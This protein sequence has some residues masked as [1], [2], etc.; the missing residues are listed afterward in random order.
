AVGPEIQDVVQGDGGR[1]GA[2]AAPLGCPFLLRV[3]LPLCQ[4]TR[5]QPLL[6]VAHDALVP[7][8]VRD[9]LPQPG[10][11]NRLKRPNIFIPLSTTHRPTT[12]QKSRPPPPATRFS[13]PFL[14]CSRLARALT[15]WAISLSPTATPWSCGPPSP[16]RMWSRHRR[17]LFSYL[18]LPRMP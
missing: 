9:A 4:H 6:Y 11:V 15:A 10:M 1:Q 13:V 2:P 7:T 18:N 16:P 17:S 3:P 8:P 12:C 5:V 14:S